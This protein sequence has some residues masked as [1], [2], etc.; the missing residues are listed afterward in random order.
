MNGSFCSQID[1]LQDNPPVKEFKKY[2]RSVFSCP[3]YCEKTSGAPVIQKI[4]D[5]LCYCD[6][7]LQTRRMQY[8]KLLVKRVNSK[9]MLKKDMYDGGR[10]EGFYAAMPIDETD[11]VN[12]T[13]KQM[14]VFFYDSPENTGVVVYDFFI[15]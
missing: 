4:L 12:Y 15:Q 9:I 14:A 5:S 3:H 11:S 1:A 13:N 6:I 2:L 10:T 7:S 8:F